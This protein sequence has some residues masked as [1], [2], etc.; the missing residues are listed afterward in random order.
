MEHLAHH[1]IKGQKWGVRRFQNPDGTLT[2]EGRRHYGV[3]DRKYFTE[4]R[5]DSKPDAAI[6]L[7]YMGYSRPEIAKILGI[8]EEALSKELASYRG[9]TYN[10][11]IGVGKIS[12]K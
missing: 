1:G 7:G 6:S 2:P 11:G 10:G 3:D 9:K 5:I 12:R 4:I 8:S